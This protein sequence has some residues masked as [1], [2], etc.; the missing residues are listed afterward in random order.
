M[1]QC[2]R[3]YGRLWIIITPC[4]S[5]FITSRYF[6]EWLSY[7]IVYIAQ[8]AGWTMHLDQ[9]WFALICRT[10]LICPW[11]MSYPFD[12]TYFNWCVCMGKWMKR[13]YAMTEND[14][15]QCNQQTC[16]YTYYILKQ[17]IK[18]WRFWFRIICLSFHTLFSNS[19][20][21]YI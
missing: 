19:K 7:H 15:H 6:L 14:S 5:Q 20:I 11:K 18:Q 10:W 8:G 16:S 13:R 4:S 17:W 2:V 9:R 1:V 21:N 3:G 12:V